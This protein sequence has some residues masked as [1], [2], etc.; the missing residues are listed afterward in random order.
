MQSPTPEEVLRAEDARC[1]A[2]VGGDFAALERFYDD[3]LV[4]H[5]TTGAI[6]GK[7]SFIELQRSGTVRFHRI[8]RH[9]ARVRVYGPVAIVTGT[10][11][12]EY[13]ARGQEM[14]V[15][16]LFHAVWLRRAE[17]LRLVSWQAT[18]AKA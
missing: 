12:F 18:R 6:D 13:N 10:G 8:N 7:A 4:Y 3:E 9:E 2:Q 11:T 5:H 16:Q 15:V 14:V 1:A 17:G